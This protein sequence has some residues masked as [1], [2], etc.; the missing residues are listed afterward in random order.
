MTEKDL[1]ARFGSLMS[2][3]NDRDVDRI[4]AA[5]SPESQFRNAA[6]RQIVRGREAVRADAE[7]LLDA[8][9]D[10]RLEMR[11]TLA[12]GS[13]VTCEWTARG[14]QRH[15]QE[16]GIR[17]IEQDGVLIADYDGS[18]QV[19]ALA[20]YETPIFA[21]PGAPPTVDD[22]PVKRSDGRVAQ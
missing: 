18:G 22:T 19:L 3:W 10:L 5:F 14:T 15:A 6:T 21:V 12:A 9:S 8:F 13:V 1:L 2:A 7:A 11:R 16:S 20:R 4:V 17:A